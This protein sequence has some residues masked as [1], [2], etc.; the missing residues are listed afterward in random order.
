MQRSSQHSDSRTARRQL[1]RLQQSTAPS[2]SSAR[3]AAASGGVR[4]LRSALAACQLRHCAWHRRQRSAPAQPRARDRSGRRSTSRRRGRRSR[5]RRRVAGWG[6]HR[7]TA[8]SAF[9]QRASTATA[10]GRA[11]RVARRPGAQRRM[12]GISAVR[13]LSHRR[14]RRMSKVGRLWAYTAHAHAFAAPAWL[15]RY[16]AHRAAGKHFRAS[17]A[18]AL[19]CLAVRCVSCATPCGACP[20]DWASAGPPGSRHGPCATPPTRRRRADAVPAAGGTR[21]VAHVSYSG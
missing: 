6:V 5:I 15:G 12:R 16:V 8:A 1:T 19:L 20:P 21:H 4:R 17:H 7:A 11:R 10:A 3:S 18:P 13:V 14:K 2:N 9:G